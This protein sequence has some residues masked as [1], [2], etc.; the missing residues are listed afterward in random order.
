MIQVSQG[1]AASE[2]DMN[3]ATTRKIEV[4]TKAVKECICVGYRWMRKDGER[5]E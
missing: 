2:T 4:D 3:A 1:A 5:G